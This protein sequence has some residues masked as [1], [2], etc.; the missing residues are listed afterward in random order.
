MPF[1]LKKLDPLL[2]PLEH[3]QSYGVDP[4][5]A[6]IIRKHTGVDEKTWKAIA[7]GRKQPSTKIKQYSP[8]FNEGVVRSMTLALNSGLN[9]IEVAKAHGMSVVDMIRAVATFAAA[10]DNEARKWDLENVE[11]SKLNGWALRDND[12]VATEK[13]VLSAELKELKERR[14]IEDGQ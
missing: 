6:A 5:Y 10:K 13:E 12:T 1:D 3:L 7:D 4:R 11:L 9:P 8:L 2:R 14:S